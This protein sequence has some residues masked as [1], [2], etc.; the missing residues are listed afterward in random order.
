M[1]HDHHHTGVGATLILTAVNA[2]ISTQ[3]PVVFMKRISLKWA[4]GTSKSP[5]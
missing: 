2:S 5:I 1:S 4:R 3:P